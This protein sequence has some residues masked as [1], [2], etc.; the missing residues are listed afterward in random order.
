MKYSLSFLLLLTS[1]LTVNAQ[2]QKIIEYPFNEPGS[3]PSRGVFG[4][5]DRKEIKDA[6]GYKDFARAT[7]VM[8]SKRNNR[9]FIWLVLYL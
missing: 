2:D 8:V 5:D 6:E 1:L 7:A 4:E 9:F 3:E